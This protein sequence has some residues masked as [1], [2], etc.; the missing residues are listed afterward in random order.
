L[1]ALPAFLP[2]SIFFGPKEGRPGILVPS[3]RS[4]TDQKIKVK[5]TKVAQIINN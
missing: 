1:L 2:S 5:V 3:P 4:A